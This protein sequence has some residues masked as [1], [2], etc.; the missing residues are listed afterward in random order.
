MR[1]VVRTV[2]LCK[3]WQR[4]WTNVQELY[5]ST[6]GFFPYEKY[7][8]FVNRA[9]ICRGT[10]KIRRLRIE[11]YLN[12]LS[13]KDYEGWIS[14]AA[15][16]NVEDLFL[17][18]D[19]YYYEWLPPQCLYC[20]SSL[21]TLK[22]WGCRFVPDMQI[23]WNSLTKLSLWFSVLRNESFR[24]IMVG[25]PKLEFFELF[26]CWGYNNLIFDSPCLRTV[27]VCEKCVL[28]NVSSVVHATLDFRPYIKPFREEKLKWQKE[29]LMELGRSLKHVESLTLGIWCIEVLAQRERRR[30][31]PQISTNKCATLNIRMKEEDLLG[32]VNLLKGSPNLQTLIIDMEPKFW[33]EPRVPDLTDSENFCI[34]NV[35]N[36][37]AS[38]AEHVKCLLHHLKTVKITQFVE[39]HSVLPFVEFILKNGR[40]LENLVITAKRGLDENSEE[41]L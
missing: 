24:E 30:I 27:N 29:N 8:A 34:D 5:F 33:E 2:I 23:R 4:L 15:T 41:Y 38:Q 25:A 36:Y 16:N 17:E 22:L 7:L 21:K 14:Y 32:I 39:Q 11:L 9:L 20:N 31:P 40:V 3:H 18:F 13:P 26:S 35:A 19:T 37:V 6:E 1:Y 12:A 10:C 28:M